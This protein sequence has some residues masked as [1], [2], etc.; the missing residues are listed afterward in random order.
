MVME[1]PS[2]VMCVVDDHWLKYIADLGMAGLD[3]QYSMEVYLRLQMTKKLSVT[4]EV[5]RLI[6]PTLKPDEETTWVFGLRARL[7]L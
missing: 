5:Q 4:P 7:S 6:N 3:D 2:N 1:A